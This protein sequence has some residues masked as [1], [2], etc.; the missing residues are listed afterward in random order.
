MGIPADFDQHPLLWWCENLGFVFDKKMGFPF[1]LHNQK[2]KKADTSIKL[3]D[4]D[5]AV[6]VVHQVV[7]GGAQDG[8]LQGPMAAGGNAGHGEGLGLGELDKG[9]LRGFLCLDDNGAGL[10]LVVWGGTKTS[11]RKNET[12]VLVWGVIPAC[13]VERSGTYALGL[14]VPAHALEEE[15]AGSLAL[16]V[17]LL[18]DLLNFN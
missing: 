18:L 3:D 4:E 10:D 11:K 17:S 16:F 7:T 6:G 12:L 9:L 13:G 5:R 2:K 1:L 14:K 8:P 15:L